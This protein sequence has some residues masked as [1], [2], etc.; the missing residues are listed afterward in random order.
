MSEHDICYDLQRRLVSLGSK[1]SIGSIRS[2]LSEFDYTPKLSDTLMYPLEEL[3]I[4]NNTD[5]FMYLLSNI[6]LSHVD[7]NELDSSL[8]RLICL[9]DVSN[10]LLNEAILDKMEHDMDLPS[11][12][13]DSLISRLTTDIN[14]DDFM[15]YLSP[16]SKVRVTRIL[17]YVK[18]RA[19][20]CNVKIRMQGKSIKERR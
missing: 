1:A 5:S 13:Y 2:V 7:Y 18:L 6:C 15:H 17:D 14:L 8:Y 20:S 16:K 11:L 19:L 3:K 12:H 4:A 10:S 9:G